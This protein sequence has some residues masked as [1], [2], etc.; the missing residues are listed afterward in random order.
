MVAAGRVLG[1]PRLSPD[2]AVV[3]FVAS[4]GG[5][6]ALVTVPA[7]GGS[8]AVLTTEPAPCSARADGGGVFDWLP[9]GSALAYAAVDGGLWLQPAEG[10]TPRPVVRRHPEGPVAA[11]ALSP[12]GT[13]VAYV[14]D[15]HH[16]AVAS[17]DP[18]GPWPVRL[19]ATADFA[20]DP[21]WSADGTR[22]AWHEWDVP[23]MPW[24][25]SRIVVR[26]SD[27]TGDAEVVAGGAG[28]AVSQPRFGPDGRLGFLCDAESGWLNLWI[29]EGDGTGARPLLVEPTEHGGP[30]WGQGA[31]TW[32]WSPDGTHVAWRTNDDGYSRLLVVALA[33]LDRRWVLGKGVHH[34]I[35]WRGARL[36]AVRTGARTPTQIVSYA[37]GALGEGRDTAVAAERVT[38]ARGPV[39]GWE[40]LDLP[41]PEV[42]RWAGD[43]G[44][45]VVG[46][47]LRPAGVERPPLLCWVHG[48]PTDQWLV[49]FNARHAY[50]LERGWAILIPDHRG[51]TGH[52]RPYT[53]ALAG[54]WGELDVADC[55]SGMQH[56]AELGTVDGARMVP[57]GSSAGGFTALLLLARHPNLCAAG[58]AVSAVADLV[59]L[60]ARSHRFEAHYTDSLVG[61]LPEA[62][63]EL[64][65]RSPLS[66]AASIVAPL[67]LLHGDA[68]PVVPVEQARALAAEL[69]RLGR[70]VDLHV[71]AGEGHGW[72][73]PDVV[74]DELGRIEAFLDAHL[75]HHPGHRVED[76]Q[77]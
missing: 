64:V 48:G 60:A 39:A 70:P 18:H 46:R 41:E 67:L 28:I 68:D 61:A 40:A 43:D 74:V 75:L 73:H 29:A 59:D 11:P 21:T 30:S 37:A 47:L 4:S 42:L 23:A 63:G 71:Y 26:R 25:S 31:R 24:D 20:F 22:V 77:V 35:S 55:A 8:E 72:G 5:G 10:G 65:A 56:V 58:V 32:C 45:E 19:S 17:L 6:A 33:D 38:V 66:W 13:R 53:Q 14:V 36:A 62:H 27:G 76:R 9:D 50:F 54:R 34:G 44:H 57:I 49:T 12:D 69:G 3:A 1:E 7:T 16:V 51:S 15:Q 2:G 52:G